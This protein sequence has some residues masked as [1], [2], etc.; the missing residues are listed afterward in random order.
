[1]AEEIA[2]FF[3]FSSFMLSMNRE[4]LF[5]RWLALTELTLEG[6]VMRA[7]C[8]ESTGSLMILQ[9]FS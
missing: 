4:R 6:L 7:V 3:C 8:V 2:S 1:M 5:K 9:L